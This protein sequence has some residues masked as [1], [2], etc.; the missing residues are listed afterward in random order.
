MYHKTVKSPVRQLINVRINVG[1]PP[2]VFITLPT[3]TPTLLRATIITNDLYI[4]TDKRT[5][6]VYKAG[7]QTK[8]D[9]QLLNTTRSYTLKQRE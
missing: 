1:G 9:K 7:L 2:Q 6:D 4:V 5:R 8:K 3:I